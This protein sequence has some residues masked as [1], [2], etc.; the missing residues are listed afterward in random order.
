MSAITLPPYARLLGIRIDEQ[1]PADDNPAPRLVMAA[2][3][4]L[5][6]WPGV[7]HGGATAGLLEMAARAAI[8]ATLAARGHH[9]PAK[10]IG[11]TID[12]TRAGQMETTYARGRVI[13]VG[14]RVATVV[15][16]AWQEA[17]KPIASARL[18][19]LISTS[20]S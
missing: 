19:M 17:G 2:G 15:V 9:V 11:L 16:E 12:Y 3:R 7:L 14:A 13:R 8:D 4:Q 6:G 1:L 5:Q 10:P 18:H 20:E